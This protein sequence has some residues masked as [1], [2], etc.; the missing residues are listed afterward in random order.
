MV[1]TAACAGLVAILGYAA[2]DGLTYYRTPTEVVYT[3]T[4]DDDQTV[5]VG[6]LVVAGSVSEAAEGSRLLLSD[7]ATDVEVLYPGRL[8]DV[9]REGQGAVVEGRWQSTGVL[10]GEQVVMRHSNEYR[11]PEQPGG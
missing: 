3:H 6:G 10:R 11:A 1:L 7:G 9:V 2:D 4:V 5:R 8:P